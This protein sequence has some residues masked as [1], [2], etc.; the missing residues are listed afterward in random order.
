MIKFC[1]R[2]AMMF[3]FFASA[4]LAFAEGFSLYEYSAR[5]LALGG[6]MVARK[7]DAS[8]VAFNGAL[9]TR[10][11]GVHAM[12]GFTGVSPS[13]KID[14]REKD[15]S[16]GTTGLNDSLWAIPH[17]YYT[18]QLSDDWFLGIGEFSRFGLGFEYPHDWPGR[19]NIYEVSLLSG[20]LNPTI[21]WKATDKLSLAAGVELVYVSLDLK[22]RVRKELAQT[23]VGPA[24][25]EVDVNIQNAEDWSVGFNLATHYQ[26]NEQWAAGLQYRSQVR[27]HAFGDA[28]FTYLG[29]SG[30]GA[31]V[32]PGFNQK[33]AAGYESSFR[34]GGANATVILPDSFA[35]GVAWTPTPELS[36]E[37][38]A[39]W[40]RWSAFKSLNIN[41]PEP[42]PKAQS[43]K[44]WKDVWR[45][46]AGVEYQPLDWLTMRAGYVWDQSP[47]TTKYE[48]YLVPT[49]DRQ[50]FSFGLGFQWEAWTLD[51][52]YAYIKPKN[53]TYRNEQYDGGT[54][55][56][57]SR[58]KNASTQLFSVS[59]GYEF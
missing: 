51:L 34:D 40:T 37:I 19:Y 42:L 56:V 48:D 41:M 2:L 32:I 55:T 31:A 38:G 12:I 57:D 35:G 16:T 11:P 33:A 7:P 53:R 52:G 9:L 59:L 22:K 15:G 36:F 26:F 13:G 6:A 49:S 44:H 39:I 3:C 10:L 1:A 45:L 50:I 47:M 28:E 29:T 17:A 58:T 25:M 43:K 8:A 21:A 20:S 18:H 24:N 46:N 23:P 30:A 14:W 27:V 54:W 4:S 5:G